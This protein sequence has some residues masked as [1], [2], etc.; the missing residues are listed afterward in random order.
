MYIVGNNK[1]KKKIKIFFNKNCKNILSE[2]ENFALAA[3]K[4]KIIL[5]CPTLSLCKN[6]EKTYT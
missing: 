1:K 6:N 2:F 3:E 5:F 4:L